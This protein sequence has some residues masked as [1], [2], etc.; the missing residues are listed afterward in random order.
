MSAPKHSFFSASFFAEGQFMTEPELLDVGQKDKFLTIGMPCETIL[1][2]SRCPL[3]PAAVRSLC[4]YGHKVIVETGA[5][6]GAHFTD[7][8]YSEAGAIISYETAEVYKSQ[9]LV[10]IAP[11]TIDE[12]AMMQM[13]QIL[14]SPLQFPVL[15]EDYLE[16][17]K[18]KRITALAM[19][20]LQSEDGSYPIVRIMSEIA[21]TSAV[22]TAAAYL[23]N[24][25][26]TGR[27]LLL[28]SV[29]GV[30]PTKIVILG[31]G[32]VAESA[33][34]VALGLGA[35]VRIFDNDITKLM[36]LQKVIG[37]HLHTSSM[38][39]D[40]LTE[41]LR[42]ADVLIGAIHSKTGR[43]PIVVTEEMVTQMKVGSVIIDI[44]ID[45]GG[46]VETSR[47]T[48]LDNPSYTHHGVIHYCVPNMPSKVSR[49]ASIA[50]SNIVSL[51]LVKMGT[52]GQIENLLYT[53]KGIRNGC[54]AYKGC[55]THEFLSRRFNQKYTNIEL[56]LTSKL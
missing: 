21:G 14:I 16:H 22:L 35:A 5:G 39:P 8:D 18:R 41:E 20:Y 6:K 9:V 28:G 12:I 55:I 43:T 31:S 19:E 37:S 48:T 24:T 4:G 40:H 1:A 46:C 17:L 3:I 10:K 44:S 38:D 33:T 42:N 30:P 47:V 25:I 49:T 26:E 51:L 27:G 13:D 11:P 7:H 53:H 32:V 45:Q 56:L 2:E 52:V 29:S 34:K 23:D 54:Y 50:I 36:R 15:N